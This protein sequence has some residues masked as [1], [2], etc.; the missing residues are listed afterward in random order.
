MPSTPSKVSASITYNGGQVLHMSVQKKLWRFLNDHE[1]TKNNWKTL[2]FV[3]LRS[4]SRAGI[5]GPGITETLYHLSIF[6]PGSRA[7]I[8]RPGE[9]WDTLLCVDL[10]SGVQGW[11]KRTRNNWK[12]SSFV[13][14]RTGSRAGIEGPGITETL[15][16]LSFFGPGSRAG[17]EGLGITETLYHVSVR[18]PGVT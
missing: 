16:Y 8:E 10:R 9:K 6:G 13:D 12:T 14:F 7:G 11:Q 15:Y 17:T 4:G 2:S 1:R 5:E 3:D 18:G